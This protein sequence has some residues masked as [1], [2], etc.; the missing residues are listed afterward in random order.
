[1]GDYVQ[2]PGGYKICVVMGFCDIYEQLGVF[3]YEVDGFTIRMAEGS[4]K[5]LYSGIEAII[6]YKVDRVTYDE[7]RLEVIFEECA[8][9]IT[10]DVPGWYQFVSKTKAIF[11]SIP[12]DWEL[13]IPF[14]AFDMNLTVLFKKPVGG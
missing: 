7:I 8:L 6:A 1:M 5:Y 10:E 2:L 13:Q 12:P 3:S 14:P 4:K 9:R 11:P